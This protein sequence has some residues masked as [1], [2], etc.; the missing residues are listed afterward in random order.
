MVSLER[1]KFPDP[2]ADPMVDVLIGQDQ[3]DLHFSKCDVRGNSGQPIARLGPLGW[4]CVGHSHKKSTARDPHMNLAYTLLCKPK[5]LDKIN[6]SLKRFWEIE[7]LGILQSKPE[8][9]TTEDRMRK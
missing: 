1:W 8:M 7:T 2:A 4:S 9:T 3:T 6:D 5:V